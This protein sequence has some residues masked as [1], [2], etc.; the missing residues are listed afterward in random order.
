MKQLGERP[1]NMNHIINMIIRQIMNRVIRKGIDS[2]MNAGSNMMSK[3]RGKQPPQG[4]IDDYGN[5]TGRD[6]RR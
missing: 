5:P 2:G 4:E 1:M 6:N 3:R